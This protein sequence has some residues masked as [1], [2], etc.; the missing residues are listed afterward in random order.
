MFFLQITLVVVSLTLVTGSCYWPDGT[1]Y[2]AGLEVCDSSSE[3]SHCCYDQD[4]CLDNGYCLRQ[5]RAGGYGNRIVRVGCTDST[6]QSDACKN[7]Q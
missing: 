2:S 7:L 1:D 5:N 4:A 3:H 6:W